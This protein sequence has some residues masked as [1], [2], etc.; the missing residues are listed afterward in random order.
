[1][2]SFASDNNS[3][4]SDSILKA[5]QEANYGHELAYG[6]DPYSSRLKEMF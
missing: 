3:G 2:R 6:E 1:M 5:I 4:I